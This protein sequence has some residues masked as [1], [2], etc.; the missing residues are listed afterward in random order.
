[1]LCPWDSPGK[2]TGV[3]CSALLQETFLTWE[4]NLPACVS[5]IADGSFTTEPCGKLQP[6]IGRWW[7]CLVP[8]K[9]AR[10]PWGLL[11]EG[12]ISLWLVRKGVIITHLTSLNIS[13]CQVHASVCL[14]IY[15]SYVTLETSERGSLTSNLCYVSY[16]K[17][18]PMSAPLITQ[19]P[20]GVK[21]QGFMRLLRSM[22]KTQRD[23]S[24]QSLLISNLLWPS[25]D[26][27]KVTHLHPSLGAPWCVLSLFSHVWFLAIPWAIARQAPLSMGILQ[28]RILEWVAL[29]SSR[30]PSQSGME[31]TCSVAPAL[32]VDSL[33]LSP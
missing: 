24:K 9:H 25:R 8:G 17:S 33:P 3:G 14:D 26:V 13:I 16:T 4:L 12:A 28:E 15:F 31:P 29:P 21:F 7:M 6:C 20:W 19:S 18:Q 27:Q 5:C 30:G 23:V 11:G 10:A 2:S 1:M 32:P 22:G